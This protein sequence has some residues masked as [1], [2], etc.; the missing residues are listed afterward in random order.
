MKKFFNKKISKRYSTF[1]I[2]MFL[3][4]F[5]AFSMTSLVGKEEMTYNEF[6]KLVEDG[7]VEKIDLRG[8][9]NEM[10]VYIEDKKKTSIVPNPKTFEFKETML[11]EDIEVVNKQP[12]WYVLVSVLSIFINIALFALIGFII[13]KQFGPS[14]KGK[15]VSERPDIT[16]KDIAGNEEAKEDMQFLVEFLKNDKKYKD[17][18][19]KLPKGVVLFGPP[20]TGKTLMAKAVAGESNVPFYYASGSDFIEMFVGLGAK[21]VRDLFDQAKKNSPCIIFIDEVDAIGKK[22]GGFS[23]TSEHDQ[24]INAFLDAMDGFSSDESVIVIAATNRIEDLDPAFI[25]PGRFDRHVNIGLPDVKDRK[26]ILD[27]YFKNKKVNPEVNVEN[28]AKITIGF[29]GASLESLVNEAAIIAVNNGSEEIREQDIDDAYFKVAMK[30]NKKKTKNEDKDE[31][32]LIAYHEAGHALAAKLLTDSSVHKVTIVS[33][34][35]GAGGVTF[36]TPKKVSLLSKE[37]IE[38]QIKILYSGRAAE[39]VLKGSSNKITS[40]ASQ[41]IKQATQYLKSYFGELGMGEN[42]GMIAFDKEEVYMKDAIALSKQLYAESLE[43]LKSNREILKAIAER[44]LEKETIVEEE[45]DAIVEE[46]KI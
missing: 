19:A 28:L 30:G 33:S 11:K 10:F 27:L 42:F 8:N 4:I 23:Q 14:T 46:F 17:I 31:L 2:T 35:S 6:L 41:D 45:L 16:F 15:A 24:T 38:N 9:Q 36:F 37:E 7:K 26:N 39:E 5:I 18:G 13:Y 3:S 40:G 21:R 43:M 12:L 34:T 32:K 1:I 25:R 44:L 29:S 22:R 20:G